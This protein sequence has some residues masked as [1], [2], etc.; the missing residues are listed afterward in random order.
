VGKHCSGQN[1]LS[2]HAGPKSAVH[3]IGPA[4]GVSVNTDVRPTKLNAVTAEFMPG[5]THQQT[6]S[7]WCAEHIAGM[8]GVRG[9]IR[10]ARGL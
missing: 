9:G 10:I 4:V 3:L 8:T 5:S 7:S 6:N 1:A 2:T